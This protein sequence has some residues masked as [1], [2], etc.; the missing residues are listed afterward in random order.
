MLN[1]KSYLNLIK[2]LSLF[3]ILVFLLWQ[4]NVVYAVS[5]YKPVADRCSAVVWSGSDCTGFPLEENNCNSGTAFPSTACTTSWC[6]SSYCSTAD[7]CSGE[8][9]Y[10]GKTC[11]GSGLCNVARGD[12]GCCLDSKCG[13]GNYCRISTYGCVDGAHGSACD[14]AGDCD[15]TY[16]CINNVCDHAPTLGTCTV[17]DTIVNTGTDAEVIEA[18]CTYSDEEGWA[19][20]DYTQM[21]VNYVAYEEPKC[22]SSA[23]P[24][25]GGYFMFYPDTTVFTETGDYGNTWAVLDTTNS[26]SS[27]TGTTC[28]V[29]YIWHYATDWVSANNDIGMN[30]KDNHN[31]VRIGWS[32]PVAN[33]DLFTTI[34]GNEGD[35]CAEDTDCDGA[36]GCVDSLCAV[37]DSC[38]CPGLNQSWQIDMSD[39]CNITDNCDLGTGKLS[40]TGAGTARC[41]AVINTTDLGDP[42]SGAILYIDAA[43]IIYID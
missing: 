6:S 15:G 27:C 11:N 40:F 35:T 30:V 10:T 14:D 2:G 12:I 28:T 34:A 29:H 42:G 3:L 32:T 5:G 33:R 41:G 7:W 24:D 1:K 8:T 25:C 17:D 13:A 26:Y 36:L 9:R 38:S 18:T 31:S 20:I 43:C 22:T 21:L 4:P 19:D 23:D 37:A 39:N 16:S